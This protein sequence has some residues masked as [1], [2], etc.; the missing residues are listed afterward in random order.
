MSFIYHCL[1]SQSEKNNL[2][3]QI[4]SKKSQIGMCLVWTGGTTVDGYGIIRY[5]FRNKHLNLGV[6][7]A[8]FYI[9]NDRLRP[10]F[11]LHVSH[12]CQ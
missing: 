2:K 3:Q 9:S 4:M 10:L 1:L 7:R 6:Y 5:T 12:L 8:L 11:D